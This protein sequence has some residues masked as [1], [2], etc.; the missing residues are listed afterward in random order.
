I[1]ISFQDKT[2]KRNKT[3]CVLFLKYISAKEKK[4]TTNE[5]ENIF[6]STTHGISQEKISEKKAVLRG[7]T[8][9]Q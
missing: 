3:L 7:W 4:L 5:W 2:Y 6:E 8:N 9:K 1:D